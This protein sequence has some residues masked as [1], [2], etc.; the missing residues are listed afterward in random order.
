MVV[1]VCPHTCR[2][3]LRGRRGLRILTNEVMGLL[4]L[5]QIWL[6]ACVPG[7]LLGW[8]HPALGQKV[9]NWRVYRAAD[10][11]PET[12]CASVTIG[13]HGRILVKHVTQPFVTHLDGYSMRRIP[14]PETNARK[15]YESPAGQLW[16]P[17][18]R[19]LL[20][21]KDGGWELNEVPEIAA[22]FASAPQRLMTMP[23]RP[24]RQGL[25]LFLLPETLVAYNARELS[26]PRTEVLQSAAYSSLGVFSSLSLAR[27]G[28]LW[29][30]GSNGIAKS[31]GP[32]R[33]LRPDAP[34]TEHIP[35]KD[36]A[37]HRFQDPWE[38]EDGSVTAMAE[39][40]VTT[41]KVIVSFDGHRWT[42]EPVPF[43]RVRFG[44]RSPD[45]SYWAVTP[46][47][48]FNWKSGAADVV[49]SEEVSARQYFEAAVE[50]GGPFW[51]ATSDGLFRYAP[52]CW[53]QPRAIQHIDSVV[54]CVGGD[55]RERL[56][57]V[58]G[59]S[60]HL[61]QNDNYREYPIPGG[62]LR[63]G[64]PI[65]DLYELADGRLL[66]APSTGA[67]LF[68]PQAGM[69][70]SLREEIERITGQ[71]SA[72]PA[73]T[74]RPAGSPGGYNVLGRWKQ[75]VIFL[76]PATQGESR[77]IPE[78]LL[79]DGARLE[80]FRSALVDAALGTNFSALFLSQTGD[81]WLGTELGTAWFH[82]GRWRMFPAADDSGPGAP[83]TFVELSDGKTWCVAQDRVWEFDGRFWREL[84]RSFDRVNSIVRA[85][86]GSVWL[87][88]NVGCFRYF[89]G[90]WIENGV[91]EGL[92]GE[93]A[94]S[95]YEDARGRVWCATTHGVSVYHPEADPDAPE[96]TIQPL[97]EPSG[98]VREGMP[99]TLHFGG[100]DKWKFTGRDRL[101]FSYRLDQR[102]WSEFS[103]VM[104]VTYTDLPAGKHYFQ[105]RALDRNG[106]IGSRPARLEFAVILPWHKETRLVLILAAGLALALFFAALAFNRHVQ[107]LRSY[108]EVEKK[109]AERTKELEFANRE[110]LHSQKMTALGTLSAGIAHDFNNILSIIKGSAQIIEENPEDTGKIRTRID[111]I[112]TVVE[113]G[114][115]IVK[116]MLGFSRDSSQQIGLC[117]I[118]A[119]VEDTIRL[120]GDRFLRETRV[121]SHPA[122]DLPPLV[123]AKDLVQQILLNFVFNAAE[124]MASRKEIIIST[125]FVER[126]AREMVLMPAKA[127]GYVEISVRDFGCGISA[128][129]LPRVFEP[130]FTTKAF[131]SRRGT[132]LGLSM[133]YELAK[134]LEAG[135]AV[136]TVVNQ[137]STFTLVLP[138]R[139]TP[140][141]DLESAAT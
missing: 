95:L 52:P 33:N 75:G 125:R 84:Q 115:G 121:L 104:N 120:L 96:P 122:P 65:R 45:K 83:S 74:A 99:V 138:V 110:L 139:T 21:F 25:V 39:S 16:V 80:P 131:S 40:A 54:H 28:G 55:S 91:P 47:S 27:D 134:K 105:V 94:R 36:L 9:S 4:R 86:D 17:T 7:I 57:F 101:L 34:W 102:E 108:A 85:R 14:A 15:I 26:E 67:I 31:P 48:L 78:V 63:P 30:A 81:Y 56:W 135:L 126:L 59:A 61:L 76:Q 116:A 71:A 89:Q 111:R 13:S 129:N 79:F 46:A 124:S 50:S 87:A 62:L 8:V 41:Q 19:G 11:M 43:E 136:E 90:A 10:G 128:Q 49:E 98:E 113:Q 60:L 51:L 92:A 35:P 29:I 38:F 141:G 22:H 77:D 109:V 117:D 123:S 70:T 140:P 72:N 114:A 12:P 127:P 69:Y 3:G 32:A 68:D 103:D 42:S 73:G 112:K 118:N 137:G 23:I 100:V 2:F 5:R 93:G 6:L 88:S 64:A 37:L 18:H 1:C 106:N 20:E 119:V 44:W 66:L 58:T 53:R 97:R 132:G 133:V 130:F 82:E 24:V 107:L